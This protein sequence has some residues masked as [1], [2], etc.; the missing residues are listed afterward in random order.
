[1]RAQADAALHGA[2]S[3]KQAQCAP[4]R[5]ERLALH[6]LSAP[7]L[8]PP[9][10]S[11]SLQGGRPR[12][13]GAL[14]GGRGRLRGARLPRLRRLHVGCVRA[15]SL[16]PPLHHHHHHRS[17]A[18]TAAPCSVCAE[19]FEVSD[20]TQTCNLNQ[21]QCG[22][23][24]SKL[25]QHSRRTVGL[26]IACSTYCVA[27]RCRLGADAHALVAGRRVLRHDAAAGQAHRQAGR[28]RQPAHGGHAD[29]RRGVGQARAHHVGRC[30]RRHDGVGPRQRLH[31]QQGP[32]RV[33]WR[34]QGN[35][36]CEDLDGTGQGC[37]GLQLRPD[38]R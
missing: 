30:A 11:R 8:R 27:R 25:Q 23:G 2:R 5:L 34:Q 36:G 9:P 17:P 29:L 7:R 32:L 4:L 21:L 20:G 1:M 35:T 26:S 14:R 13:R 12:R 15:R 6:A 37:V 31:G 19:P 28:G 16:P 10:R 38:A 33:H 3:G 18:L 22:S 24:A